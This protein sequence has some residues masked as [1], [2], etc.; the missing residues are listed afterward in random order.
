MASPAHGEQ[1]RSSTL[2]KV[3]CSASNR[4]V[5]VSAAGELEWLIPKRGGGKC[6]N[7]VQSKEEKLRAGSKWIRILF[8][9]DRI[10]VSVPL[11]VSHYT[12]HNILDPLCVFVCSHPFIILLLLHDFILACRPSEFLGY[13]SP[14]SMTASHCCFWKSLFSQ[15]EVSHCAY[16]LSYVHCAWLISA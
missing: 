4:Y 9:T 16:M 15:F 2:H 11:Y 6:V 10:P 1:R 5:V 13:V 14:L 8:K 12:C 7:E 3:R